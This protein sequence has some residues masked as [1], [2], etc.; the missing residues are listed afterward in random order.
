MQH[1]FFL[2]YAIDRQTIS[3]LSITQSTHS[4]HLHNSHPHPSFARIRLECYENTELALRARTQVPAVIKRTMAQ[5]YAV[6]A[7]PFI[8]VKG[9]THPDFWK[10]HGE[11]RTI[12]SDDEVESDENKYLFQAVTWSEAES[13]LRWSAKLPLCSN[14]A[15]KKLNIGCSPEDLSNSKFCTPQSVDGET[16]RIKTYTN[17]PFLPLKKKSPQPDLCSDSTLKYGIEDDDIVVCTND[18]LE[19]DNKPNSYLYDFQKELEEWKAVVDQVLPDDLLPLPLAYTDKGNNAKVAYKL[20]YSLLGNFQAF[21][22]S[23]FSSSPGGESFDPRNFGIGP[24]DSGDWGDPVH[25]VFSPSFLHTNAHF[26][27]AGTKRGQLGSRGLRR[28]HRSC[29]RESR[30]ILPTRHVQLMP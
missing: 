14:H 20:L 17:P 13:S 16:Y 2:G 27:F 18:D 12:Y 9:A 8:Y 6:I 21:I 7:I 3:S 22:Q 26:I 30:S 24:R 5:G 1:T 23:G 25:L 28:S 15:D 19:Y 11:I 10:R 4:Y 29:R